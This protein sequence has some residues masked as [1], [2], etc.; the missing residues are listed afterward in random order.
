MW[1][2][3]GTTGTPVQPDISDYDYEPEL[4]SDVARENMKQRRADAKKPKPNI[5]RIVGL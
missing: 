5:Y 4:D 1:E 3:N 2:D